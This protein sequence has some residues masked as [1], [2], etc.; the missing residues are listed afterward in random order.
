MDALISTFHL[1]IKLLLAQVL[2]F[3]IVFLIL[4]FL[5]FRPLFK[6][7]GDRSRTIQKGLDDAA[8]MEHRLE[9]AKAEQAEMIKEAKN[10]AAALLEEANRQAEA[11]KADF[12]SKAKE[13]VG[14]LINREKAKMQADK[15]ETLREIRS[16]VAEMIKDGWEKI[17]GEKMDKTLDEKLIT[18]ALKKH[19]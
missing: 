3:A 10:E 11:R 19:D 6:V 12:I 5:V 1:D 13:E 18:K 4:Y 8:E 2:N 14:M 15:A 16:E 9:A 17:L 7:M